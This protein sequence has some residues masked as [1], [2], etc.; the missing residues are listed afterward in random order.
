MYTLSEALKEKTAQNTWQKA[1]KYFAVKLLKSKQPISY[2][3]NMSELPEDVV[4]RIAAD[5][6]KSNNE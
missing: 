1:Q 5:I 3:A 4:R 2:V 6:E